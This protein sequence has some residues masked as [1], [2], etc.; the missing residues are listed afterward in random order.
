MSL[1]ATHIRFALDLKEKYQVRDIEKYISGTI[2][3]DS[4]YVTKINR[5]LT[6]NDDI[7]KPEFAKDDFR[8]GWQVHQ[9][10]DIMQNIMKNKVLPGPF[11]KNYNGYDE[12]H[13]INYTAIN[14]IR[15][16]N[17]MQQFPIQEYLKF[18]EYAFNPNGENIDDIKKY[19]QIIIDLY[20]N[21]KRTSAE[22]YYNKL[23]AL[24]VTEE[25]S[26]KVKRKTEEFLK[27]KR[28]VEKIEHTYIDMIEN[29]NDAFNNLE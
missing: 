14:I 5:E 19:N 18:L 22:D 29:Y 15:D 26:V 24:G 6:H 25:L 16:M 3:P 27:D 1:E 7:L 2:Y 21:K 11:S 10:C 20:K 9:I 13:W 8:I 12:H 23:H 4:R 28:L 17:D